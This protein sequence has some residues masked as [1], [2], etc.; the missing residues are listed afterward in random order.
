MAAIGLLI[1]RFQRLTS[2][3]LILFFIVLLPANIYAAMLRVNLQTA[4]FDGKGPSYLWIRVPLQL[5]F[6]GWVWYF[7]Y[8]RRSG[9]PGNT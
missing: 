2:I 1:P 9:V 8:R 7:G 6:I 4:N 3:L 5:V